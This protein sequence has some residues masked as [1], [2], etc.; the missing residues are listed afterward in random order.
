M[1]KLKIR[2]MT[3]DHCVEHVARALRSVD[4]VESAE[5]DLVTDSAVVRF[6]GHRPSD[7]SLIDAV[8]RAGYGAQVVK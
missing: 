8:E 3:C 6:N 7:K 4:G 2:G 1:I 5:V